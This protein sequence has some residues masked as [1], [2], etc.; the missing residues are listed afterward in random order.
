MATKGKLLAIAS[1]A[2]TVALEYGLILPVLLLLVV[3]TMDVSRLI[4]TYA[5]LHRSVEAAARCGAIGACTAGQVA[6][7]AVTEAWGLSV[8]AGTFTV[9]TPACGMQVTAN[10]D[11]PLLIPWIGGTRPGA[12]PNTITLT[13]SSCYP[14]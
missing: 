13:V 3:G 1:A 7:R 4:W 8:T 9:T 10:H 11:F 2:G 5:T 12:A 14:L 6:A